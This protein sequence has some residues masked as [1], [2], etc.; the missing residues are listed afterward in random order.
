MS[1]EPLVLVFKSFQDQRTVGSSSLKNIRIRELP[2]EKSYRISWFHERIGQ[3]TGSL[4]LFKKYPN[5]G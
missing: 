5:Y 3:I 4:M 2:V 1:I